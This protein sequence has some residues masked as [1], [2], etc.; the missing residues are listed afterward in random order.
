MKTKD[1]GVGCDNKDR[2]EG[3][4]VIT[5]TGQRA[6]CENKGQRGGV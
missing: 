1:R 5:K 3:W 2:T 6:Q 4:G